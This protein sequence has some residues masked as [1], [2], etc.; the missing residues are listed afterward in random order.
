VMETN[1]PLPA[2]R[3]LPALERQQPGKAEIPS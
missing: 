1:K 3:E 2:T